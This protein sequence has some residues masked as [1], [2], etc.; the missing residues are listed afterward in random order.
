MHIHPWEPR[1]ISV[2]EALAIQ[3]A[4]ASFSLPQDMSL[5]AMFKGIGNA[6]P[7]LLGKGIASPLHQLLKASDH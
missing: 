4:P 5:T 1:R 3:S 6:V 7:Y 2:A